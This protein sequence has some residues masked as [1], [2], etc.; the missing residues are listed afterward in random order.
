MN[1]PLAFPLYLSGGF[2]RF[3]RGRPPALASRRDRDVTLAAL[4][5]FASGLEPADRPGV[6]SLVE[7]V[8]AEQAG[9]NEALAP[10]VS[11]ERLER[12]ARR[13][14]ELAAAAEAR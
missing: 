8:R 5:G 12:L 11:P 10:E 4:Q 9:A 13:L 3:Y 6:E 1:F 7:R 14:R 2:L